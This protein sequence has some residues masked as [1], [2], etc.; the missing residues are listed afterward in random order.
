MTGS[1]SMHGGHWRRAFT[2]EEIRGL[3]R[4]SNLQ[5]AW[6]VASNWL[7][8]AGAAALVAWWPNVLTVLLAVFLIGSRQLGLAIVMH[9]AAHRTLFTSRRLNDWAGNWLAAHWIFLSVEL[10]RPYHL[11]HHAHTGSE[12]DPDMG[13]KRGFPTTTASMARKVARDLL[14]V[15]GIKRLVGTAGFLLSAA[16]GRR[17]RE[18]Q[19]ITFMGTEVTRDAAARAL[20]GFATTQSALLG[21]LWALGRPELF[22][23]WAAAWLTTQ[24]LVTRIRSIAE[25]AMTP[26]TEDPFR[27]TRTVRAGWLARLFV[28]PNRVNHH[29]EHHLLMT[30]PHH[31]LPRLHAMLR[32][33]GLLE[34]AC[35]ADSYAHVLRAATGRAG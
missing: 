1:A 18:G 22:A 13:L 2:S 24:N 31:R 32:D 9:E 10:Y 16:F 19:P 12:R 11:Q 15:V 7:L 21:G 30:V 25:H 4:I 28:A 6:M 3:R 8:M 34:D 33:R 29:L 26:A 23:L 20:L 27:N 5:G 14:G 17:A 35:V